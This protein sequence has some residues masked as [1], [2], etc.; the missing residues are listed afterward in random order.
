[1]SAVRTTSACPA[2]GCPRA[3]GRCF[4]CEREG[5]EQAREPRRLR[6]MRRMREQ[7]GRRE[8]MRAEARHVA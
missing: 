3:W 4:L 5:R 7:A 1:M 2:C 8:H 6:K